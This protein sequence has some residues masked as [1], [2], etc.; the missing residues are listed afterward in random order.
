[1]VTVGFDVLG[2][3]LGL[4]LCALVGTAEGELEWIGVGSWLG[5]VDGGFE[6]DVDIS[7]AG[8]L[9]N[10]DTA[11]PFKKY[12][13]KEGDSIVIGDCLCELVKVDVEVAEPTVDL[14]DS[15]GMKTLV[16]ND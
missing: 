11:E 6:G 16:L 7:T 5:D 2:C 15:D 4:A 1:M 14:D 12:P 10:S 9:V 8:T 13:A 3:E